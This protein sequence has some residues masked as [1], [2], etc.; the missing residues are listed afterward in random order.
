M[1]WKLARSKKRQISETKALS[2]N[3]L[4]FQEKISLRNKMTQF[5]KQKPSGAEARRAW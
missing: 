5:A 2:P 1:G 4:S 3:D